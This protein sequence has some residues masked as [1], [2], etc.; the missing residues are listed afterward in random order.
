M[1]VVATK[2]NKT[3][4]RKNGWLNWR[5]ELLKGFL[6]SIVPKFM[7]HY[8]GWIQG[9]FKVWMKCQSSIRHRS[10]FKPYDMME[11]VMDV[12]KASLYLEIFSCGVSSSIVVIQAKKPHLSNQSMPPVKEWQSQLINWQKYG[13]ERKLMLMSW[14]VCAKEKSSDWILIRKIWRMSNVVVGLQIPLLNLVE[15]F[16]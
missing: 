10:H 1:P 2:V 7:L 11:N 12:V 13:W 15:T 16:G 8:N 4:R 5:K 6:Y 14:I 3:E 9:G